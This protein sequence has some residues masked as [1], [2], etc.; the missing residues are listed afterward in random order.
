MS[1]N[2]K[3]ALAVMSSQGLKF[4]VPQGGNQPLISLYSASLP[5]ATTYSVDLHVQRALLNKIKIMNNKTVI[6]EAF[7]KITL[8]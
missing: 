2:G 8:F 3:L 7:E 4:C 6:T 1:T 5:A